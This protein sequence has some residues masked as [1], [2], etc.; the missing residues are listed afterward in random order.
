[1]AGSL[2]FFVYVRD[3]GTEAAVQ[4]DEDTGG[5]E[6]LG[7]EP[8]TGA[9]PLELLPKGAKMRYVN[10]VQTTGAGAGYRGRPF[11]CGT[12]DADAFSGDAA[13]FEL[14]GLTH[15]VTSSRGERIRRPTAFNTGLDGE[16]S[17]VGGGDG[18]VE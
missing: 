13:T 1:M 16:S 2:A 7:F 10:T 12:P 3:D 15:A 17:E 11:P 14:N 8:Y 4:L 9:P 18:G 5:C 6:E